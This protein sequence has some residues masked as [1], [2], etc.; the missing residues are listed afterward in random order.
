MGMMDIMLR[1]LVPVAYGML[2]LVVA[3]MDYFLWGYPIFCA[4]IFLIAVLV[5]VGFIL[6]YYLIVIHIGIIVLSII[7]S[8]EL[9]T[10]LI[11]ILS[12]IL[13][14]PNII[15]LL[16]FGLLDYWGILWMVVLFCVDAYFATVIVI[17]I[18]AAVLVVVVVNIL[19]SIMIIIF[20]VWLPN[21]SIITIIVGNILSL[22]VVISYFVGYITRII[23]DTIVI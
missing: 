13:F 7:L 8:V 16:V 3:G 17:I 10:R 4:D 6:T 19:V 1:I 12:D 18:V 11:A 14:I 21:I 2:L 5:C 9:C 20:S 23:I 15:L 22:F